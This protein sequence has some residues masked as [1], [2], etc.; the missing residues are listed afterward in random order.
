MPTKNKGYNGLLILGLVLGAFN[1]VFW[2]L[3]FMW[4]FYST[5]TFVSCFLQFSEPLDT[6]MEFVYFLIMPLTVFALGY[7]SYDMIRRKG[8]KGLG[9]SIFVMVLGLLLVLP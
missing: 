2:V 5:H 8:G 7:F 9:L 3:A 1:L 6:I 4:Y